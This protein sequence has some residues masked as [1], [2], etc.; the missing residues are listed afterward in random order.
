[1][2]TEDGGAHRIIEDVVAG[3]AG[4]SNT[5][6]VNVNMADAVITATLL[7]TDP[8]GTPALPEGVVDPTDK[9]LVNDLDLRIH[10]ATATHLPWKLDPANPASAALS[11]DN[12]RDNVEQVEISGAGPGAYFVQVSQKGTLLNG[13]SQNYS[14]IISVV[15]REI[16]TTT[17]IESTDFSAGL[18]AGW[19]TAGTGVAWAI[20]TPVAGDPREDNLNGGAGNFAWVDNYFQ[21]SDTEL[22]TGSYDLSGYDGAILTFKT[23]FVFELFETANVEV[24]TNGGTSW[25]NV[26]Q[27][28]GFA[29]PSS[30]LV[31]LSDFAGE[32]AV[33][34]RFRYET[35]GAAA[36]DLWQVDDFELKA[37]TVTQAPG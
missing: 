1:V 22:R 9:M 34:I 32:S 33:L 20:K 16:V 4:A 31:D 26:W 37:V 23:H 28:Q 8:P 30:E 15:P 3:A 12:D 27:L 19:S 14:L 7:W 2:I 5:V 17:I 29:L 24:S 6:Q 35:G 18:P 10:D 21:L 13:N 25:T 36:G 11:G